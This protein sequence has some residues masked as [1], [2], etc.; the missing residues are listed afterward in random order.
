MLPDHK[1]FDFSFVSFLCGWYHDTKWFFLSEPHNSWL[2]WKFKQH[3][4]I[5]IQKKFKRLKNNC[6]LLS[7]VIWQM[8]SPLENCS[9]TD[10]KKKSWNA[11]G[12]KCTQVDKWFYEGAS[13]P[14]GMLVM[15]KW[16]LI[17]VHSQPVD[18]TGF[19][20]LKRFA[21]VVVV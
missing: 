3:F 6:V 18:I 2:W 10:Q 5:N 21:L 15:F 16:S 13:L 14:L 20:K 7:K 19:V 8:P 12:K 17:K 11:L 4:F 1:V 9:F